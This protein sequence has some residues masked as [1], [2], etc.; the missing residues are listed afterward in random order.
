MRRRTS[1]SPPVA[2]KGS[3]HDARFGDEFKC[4]PRV[5]GGP[6]RLTGSVSAHDK[7]DNWSYARLK[8]RKLDFNPPNRGSSNSL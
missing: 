4:S 2:V 7:M 5:I 1:T 3:V 8:S 6:H